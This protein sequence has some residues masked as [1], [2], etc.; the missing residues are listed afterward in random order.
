ML[1]CIIPTSKGYAVSL[2]QFTPEKLNSSNKNILMIPGFF[3]RRSVM[4][5]LA[6]EMALR[7]GFRVLTMD[8]RGR[9]KQTMPK[10]GKKEGWTVDDYI[11]S[12]FPEVLRWI[13]RQY[14]TE[15]TVVVG[16]SMGEV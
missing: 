11:Q 15:R 12:D 2:K 6:K 1:P 16:H 4:D 13:R 8:M 14:P 10:N 7:Y 9:S 5:K 3:C